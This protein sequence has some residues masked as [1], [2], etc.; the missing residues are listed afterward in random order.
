MVEEIKSIEQFKAEIER[1]YSKVMS[2]LDGSRSL[3][4]D[5]YLG[6]FWEGKVSVLNEYKEFI[7]IVRKAL[8]D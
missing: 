7:E 4:Q 6:R 8:K 5:P 3:L 2:D 1:R